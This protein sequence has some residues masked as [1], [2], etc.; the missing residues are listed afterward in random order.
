MQ[1][2]WRKR[3]V[4]KKLSK[5]FE[6]KEIISEPIND[7]IKIGNKPVL[8]RSLVDKNVYL[9][10]CFFVERG[11]FSSCQAVENKYVVNTAFV[12]LYGC[13]KTIANK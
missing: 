2:I 1:V 3:G 13:I 9:I 5:Y 12:S 6:R 7:K 10:K 8:Y 11:K 4:W